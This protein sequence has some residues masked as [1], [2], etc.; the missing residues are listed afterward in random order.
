MDKRAATGFGLR[1]LIISM[2]LALV[3]ACGG[4]GG[5]SAAVV[6]LQ[7]GPASPTVAKGL[8]VD[9]TATA[10]RDNSRTDDV[11]AEATWTSLTPG[12]ASVFKGK[13]TGLAVGTAEIRASF[14]GVQQSIQVSVTAARIVS[15]AV[16]PSNAKVGLGATQKFTATATMT[17]GSTPDVSG[18]ATW[19]VLNEA[20][21]AASDVVTITGNGQ[22]TTNRIGKAKIQAVVAA[23]TAPLVDF[24]VISAQFK[25]IQVEPAAPS[26]PKGLTQQLSATELLTNGTPTV[27]TNTATWTT[28]N[29][30]I[31]TVDSEGAERGLVTGLEPGT[32]TITA[33]TAKGSRSVVVTVVDATLQSIQVETVP[34]GSGQLPKGGFERKFIATG[35]FSDTTTRDLTSQA[36][37]TSSDESIATISNADATKGIATSTAN[38]GDTNITAKVGTVT[39]ADFA[40]E[41]TDDT[42]ESIEVTP[43]SAEVGLGQTQQFTATGIFGG[44]LPSQDLTKKV[45]W[46]SD[47][48]AIAT[49]SN[50]ADSKGLA[51]TQSI[52]DTPATITAKFGD[53]EGSTDLTVTDAALL[54][55]VISPDDS[56]LPKTFTRA[57]KA[58]GSYS[59]GSVKDVT[60]EVTWSSS[61]SSIATI[62]NVTTTKG[63]VRGG[64][65]GQATITATKRLPNDVVVSDT[66]RVIVTD[67]VLESISVTPATLTLPLGLGQAFVATG[68]FSDD[69]TMDITEQVTWTSADTNVLSISNAGGTKG[70]AVAKAL[71]TSVVVTAQKDSLSDT[72]TVQV[73]N[74][75]V[76]T[77]IVRPDTQSCASPAPGEDDSIDLP[78]PFSTGLIACASYSDGVVRNVTTE[79]TWSSTD[80]SVVTV[81]NDSPTKG[82]ITAARDTIAAV[83]AS[84]G[85]KTDSIQVKVVAATLTAITVTPADVV[86]VNASAPVQFVATGSFTGDI[87]L[88]I[89]R[90]VTWTVSSNTVTVS[91][92]AG[93]NGQVSPAR[94]PTFAQDV[95]VTATRGTI[96]GEQTFERRANPAAE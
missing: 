38:A 48:E 76:E 34:A 44:G 56:V 7:L 91:N 47:A 58:T 5:G 45:T 9:L 30:A 49:I 93:K 69:S 92:E 22:G 18:L 63:V 17:D 62:S 24:E 59:D 39:S 65:A 15:L 35:I 87:T 71:S 64:S 1:A 4:G 52:S 72:A 43:A 96:K 57:L 60:G 75:A 36:L 37:W 83:A 50:A 90:N 51:M 77:L 86:I 2:L 12:V 73:T 32:A 14:D 68:S 42:L 10:I 6:R 61:S 82:V 81:S 23:A 55:I 13:V 79:V 25:E 33:T 16:T 31:A 67:A 84:L 88:N 66:T 70:Q 11:T 80:S 74:P 53:V 40:L 78:L 20:G 41:V 19:S 46:S 28:S 29:A 54:S 94:S 8:T 89:T 3:T 95:T 85:G 26:I 21:T 27:V